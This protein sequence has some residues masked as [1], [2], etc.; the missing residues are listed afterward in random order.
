MVRTLN[1]SLVL[2]DSSLPEP[3]YL[4]LANELQRIANSLC[5][6]STVRFPSQ[7][8]LSVRLGVDRSTVR[9]AYN[10]LLRRKFIEYRSS[11]TLYVSSESRRQ[12]VNPFPSI[13][14]IIPRQF[15]RMVDL[16]GGF[17]LRYISGIIDSATEKNI[18]TLMVQLPTADSAASV[19]KNYLDE[20][21]DRLIGL[22]HL[23]NRDFCP[24]YPL[25][26]LLSDQR[27]AQVVVS[28]LPA[29]A[30]IGAVVA[31]PTSG[32]QA[33]A[34][35]LLQFR[36]RRIG[37]LLWTD[38]WQQPTEAQYFNYESFVRP[39]KIKAV[40]QEYGLTCTDEQSLFSCQSYQRVYAQITAMIKNNQLPDAFCC[41]ND[42]VA[43]WAI[44]ACENNGLRVPEDISVIGFDGCS[45]A[46][47]QERLTTIS[48]PFYAI[49]F[50][51]VDRLIDYQENG[52]QADKQIL[53]LQTSLVMKKTL[54]WC[55][56]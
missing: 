29:T 21:S 35:Q 39:V 37:F 28:A 13:G 10:E 40:F 19:I 22:I 44:S 18:S 54:G 45:P 34:E 47:L 11:H 5:L 51:A 24:D 2:L 9:R 23:G 48:L 15:S 16:Q 7:R 41:C 14:I 36:H 55:R 20:L 33:L 53:K 3:L 6:N 25:Q 43:G 26:E 56:N 4:Q 50:K 12:L 42:E 30:Q 38:N 17:A 52:M 46:P 49:G 1:Y 32:A 27:I 31:D 8:E